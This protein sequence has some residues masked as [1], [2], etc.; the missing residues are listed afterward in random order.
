MQKTTGFVKRYLGTVA[1][2][3]LF[4]GNRINV[5]TQILFTV[6]QNATQY[7]TEIQ[8]QVCDAEGNIIP[9][10]WALDF[11]LSDVATGLGLIATDPFGAITAKA[12]SGVLL[13]ALTANKAFRCIT[14][15]DGTF[16]LQ[17]IDDAT[18]VLLYAAA[19]LP[20]FGVVGVSRKTVAGDYK[21]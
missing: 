12:D 9:G 4:V 2:K 7:G 13:G 6:A 10:V 16:T 5:P 20:S 15:A 17:I 11:W 14:A 18:P 19:S 3:G 1:M 21:P 8:A